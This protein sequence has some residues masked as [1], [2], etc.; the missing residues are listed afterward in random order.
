M[1]SVHAT[2]LKR[3]MDQLHTDALRKQSRPNRTP[4][5]LDISERF[6]DDLCLVDFDT[7]LQM[8]SHVAFCS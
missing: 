3:I 7:E 4:R 1:L 6:M 2:V 5:H 8:T